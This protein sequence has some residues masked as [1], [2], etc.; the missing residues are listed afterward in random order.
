MRREDE[1]KKVLD[2]APILHYSECEPYVKVYHGSS[3]KTS[4]SRAGG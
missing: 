1:G 4:S 2:I 3:N